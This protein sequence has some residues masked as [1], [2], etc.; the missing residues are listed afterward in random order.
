VASVSVEDPGQPFYWES[1]EGENKTLF[2]APAGQRAPTAP[3]FDI[4]GWEEVGFLRAEDAF[5][6]EPAP[7]LVSARHFVSSAETTL[8]FDLESM[9]TEALRAVYGV[10]QVSNLLEL[11]E[12]EY[13]VTMSFD[14]PGCRLV[15]QARVPGSNVTVDEFSGRIK[16]A[17]PFAEWLFR[18]SPRKLSRH[19]K[20]RRNRAGVA[21]RS[22]LVAGRERKLR[23]TLN[24]AKRRSR[25]RK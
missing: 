12:P 22:P 17:F 8:K 7:L 25:R 20:K 9:S 21:F 23:T 5:S 2:V 13:D 10:G 18:L 15:Y 4:S 16:F 6:I 11:P 1:G 14:Y 3:A 19:E 24:Y